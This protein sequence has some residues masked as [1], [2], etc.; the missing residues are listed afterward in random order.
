MCDR[1]PGA[2]VPAASVPTAGVPAAAG[3]PF[4]SHI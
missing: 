3:G 4:P 1:A 2:G